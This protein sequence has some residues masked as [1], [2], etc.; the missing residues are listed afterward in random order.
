MHLIFSAYPIYT[1]DESGAMNQTGQTH[2]YTPN[3]NSYSQV[4]N[5]L[6]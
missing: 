6:L 3:T 4:T 2:Y 1:M 5:F